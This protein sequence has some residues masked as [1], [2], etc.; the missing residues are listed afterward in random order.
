MNAAPP[1]HPSS[2]ITNQLWLFVWWGGLKLSEFKTVLQA[3]T[4][5]PL[6]RCGFLVIP[7]LGPFWGKLWVGTPQASLLGYHWDDM[8]EDMLGGCLAYVHG[9]MWPLH[10]WPPLSD[11]FLADPYS[12]TA[13]WR[14]V[15]KVP[16]LGPSPLGKVQ[17]P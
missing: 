1:P 9:A 16:P 7:V 10:D 14:C 8:M 6:K 3:V 13:N 15:A 17:S 5:N 4:I 12:T 11:L 2:D